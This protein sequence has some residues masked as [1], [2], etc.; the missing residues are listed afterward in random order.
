MTR[1]SPLHQS[2][3][4]HAGLQASPSHLYTHGRRR[5]NNLNCLTLSFPSQIT[6]VVYLHRLYNYRLKSKCRLFLKIDQ[7]R[8]LAAG[9]Y[10][11]EAPSSPRCL[12]V[13]FCLRGNS[14]QSRV[15]IPTSYFRPG[16]LLTIFRSLG[17]KNS[18]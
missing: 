12:F 13:L 16:L 1:H 10:L 5:S 4:L 18:N 3:T 7:Q 17:T 9:V 11:S 8:Y 6:A 14:S 2:A 15:E